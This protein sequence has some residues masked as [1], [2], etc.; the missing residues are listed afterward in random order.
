MTMELKKLQEFN[1]SG[2]PRTSDTA[3]AALLDH[4]ERRLKRLS[5]EGHMP[6]VKSVPVLVET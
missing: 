2:V 4:P 6:H 5:L 1:L 3:A